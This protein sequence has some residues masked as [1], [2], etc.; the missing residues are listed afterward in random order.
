MVVVL[1]NGL[2]LL[3]DDPLKQIRP[4]VV[5]DDHAS[6]EGQEDDQADRLDGVVDV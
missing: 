5:D 1:L 6:G 4:E 2:W 3:V